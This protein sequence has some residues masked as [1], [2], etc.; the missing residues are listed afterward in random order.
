MVR[1]LREEYNVY[2]GIG[3]YR[4]DRLRAVTNLMVTREDIDR[5][6]EAMAQ[7]VGETNRDKVDKAC[8]FF[9]EPSAVAV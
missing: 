7:I 1:R 8:A 6:V 4:G 9:K 2:L 3:A 5:V